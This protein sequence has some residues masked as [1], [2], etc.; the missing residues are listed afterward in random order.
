MAIDYLQE[1]IR[2]LKVPIVLELG[3][4]QQLPEHL[5]IQ[6][7]N[8]LAAL[9]RFCR[10]LLETMQGKV[11]AV[12][13]RLARFALLGAEGLVLLTE[14][15]EN[16]KAK[17]FYVLLDLPE[18][19]TPWDAEDSASALTSDLWCCD[20]VVVSGYAGSDCW[21][22]YVQAMKT[23]EFDLFA[24]VRTGNKS[25]AELQD[26]LT[27]GRLVHLAAADIVNR[28]G[29]GMLGRCGYS[30]VSALAGPGG[31]DALRTLRQR[32]PKLFLL[33]EHYDYTNLSLKKCAQAF[34]SFGHGA[35]ICVG[36]RIADAWIEA[37]TDGYDY[38]QQAELALERMKKNLAGIVPVL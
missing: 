25:A 34:D 21:K 26:L 2:K 23:K 14:L 7:G 1:K 6:E 19:L 37:E 33:V 31:T 29:Q 5:L 28:L 35:A 16:A 12:R 8:T 13:F 15:L 17:G 3:T 4:T 30:R 10:E 36:R 18:A 11:P 32:Y 38:L 22:P 20:G 27:G 24:V 9:A